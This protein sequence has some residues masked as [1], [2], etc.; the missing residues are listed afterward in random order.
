KQLPL[1]A[2]TDPGDGRERR[3]E[4]QAPPLASVEADREAVRLIAELLEHE[5]LRAVGTNGDGVLGVGQEHPVRLGARLGGRLARRWRHA[6]GRGRALWRGR[7]RRGG[8]RRLLLDEDV[9][10]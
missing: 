1:P 3:P 4:G 2:E 10:L 5:H 8:G 6:R 7:A 9:A